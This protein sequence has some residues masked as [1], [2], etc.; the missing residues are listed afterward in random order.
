MGDNNL[1]FEEIIELLELP[2]SAYRKAKERYDNFGEW[3]SRPESICAE[4]D[5][6]VFP[7][8]SFRLGTANR[9]LHDKEEYDLDLACK[10]RR[11]ISKAAQSQKDLKNIVGHEIKA[12]RQARGIKKEVI[13]K[14]R[15]WRLEYADSLSFHMDIV[16]CIPASEDKRGSIYDA[17]LRESKS[18]SFAKNASNLTID[19]TDERH[20]EYRTISNDWEISNPQGYALWFESRMKL[21]AQQLYERAMMAKAAS[22]DDLPVYS[23]KTPLQK[24]I[25]LLKRHRDVWA[26]GNEESKPISIII[27]TLAARAYQ[28]EKDIETAL[29]NI[30]GRMGDLVNQQIPHVP[31]PVDPSEDFADRWYRPEDAPLNLKG[32]FFRWLDQAN[33]DFSILTTAGNTTLIAEQAHRCFN[34][35]IDAASLAKKLGLSVNVV[36]AAP[37]VH[38]I[39]SNAAKPWQAEV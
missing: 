10:L 33:I 39:S 6:H 29:K 2:E 18:E 15:C 26:I 36:T 28:G 24:C 21:A 20:P 23:W 27:T 17:V 31:N 32:N 3:V 19:I 11:G 38:T 1:I 25:Q 22:I 30:L 4:L 8:G 35:K 9:P 13:P 37:R 14:N 5:P 34:T 12:Y 16:P 7:Q